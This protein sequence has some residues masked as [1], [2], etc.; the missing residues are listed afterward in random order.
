MAFFIR[1]YEEAPLT[2]EREQQQFSKGV[3]TGI[4]EGLQ[5][6][7]GTTGYRI[8]L[9]GGTYSINGIV[10][11]DDA[12]QTDFQDFGGPVSD[13]HHLVYVTYDPD[14]DT[15][16]TYSVKSGTFSSPAT[17][18]PT[19]AANGF[20]IADVWLPNTAADITDAVIN[21][22]DPLQMG[23]QLLKTLGTKKSVVMSQAKVLKS[24][25]S[26]TF[27]FDD[28]NLLALSPGKSVDEDPTRF[29]LVTHAIETGTGS[30]EYGTGFE[31]TVD[32]NGAPEDDYIMLYTTDPQDFTSPGTLTAHAM[33]WSA[34]DTAGSLGDQLTDLANLLGNDDGAFASENYYPYRPDLAN[35]VVL[36]VVDVDN[37]YVQW[38]NGVVMPVGDE[39]VDGDY[40]HYVRSISS[41]VY[42]T[43]EVPASG[44]IDL[45]DILD[46]ASILHAAGLDEAYDGF[47][48][49]SADG[50]GRIINVD[51]GP[52]HIKHVGLDGAGDAVPDGGDNSFVAALK[53]ALDATALNDPLY[54]SV[55]RGVDIVVQDTNSKRIALS[56]R[57]PYR[58][59]VN[60]AT[61]F[62]VD[63]DLTYTGGEI[64]VNF[65]SPAIS[66]SDWMSQHEN[67]E[68][69]EGKWV[70]IFDATGNASEKIYRLRVN[71]SGGYFY[72]EN[73]EGQTDIPANY[74]N[75][76]TSLPESVTQLWVWEV[77]IQTGHQSFFNDVEIHGDLEGPGSKAVSM[78]SVHEGYDN[79][80]DLNTNLA[81][82][83]TG[84]IDV[85][86]TAPGL[87]L[88]SFTDT[89]SEGVGTMDSNGEFLFHMENAS[90]GNPVVVNVR[91]LNDLTY[92][93]GSGVIT[94]N[95]DAEA[96]NNF[97]SASPVGLAICYKEDGGDPTL[98]VWDPS[99]YS[100]INSNNGFAA[101]ELPQ[102]GIIA[103]SS[104]IYVGTTQGLKIFDEEGAALEEDETTLGISSPNLFVQ[105]MSHDRNKIAWVV[106][107]GTN[108][109]CHILERYVDSGGSAVW[110]LHLD[111]DQLTEYD[112][113][114]YGGVKDI[115]LWRDKLLVVGDTGIC[116]TY[117]YRGP[118]TLTQENAKTFTD[119]DLIVVNMRDEGFMFIQYED[120][121]AYTYIKTYDWE[122][123]RNQYTKDWSAIDEGGVATLPQAVA[124]DG[125]YAY[126][127]D[128]GN[129]EIIKI[130]TTAKTGWWRKP[131]DF[132]K[133]EFRKL[134]EPT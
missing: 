44:D 78:T 132:T 8:S 19:E 1:S 81:N 68:H 70:E 87:R 123:F 90:L 121:T 51:S 41:T 2:F 55:E 63:A 67:L 79:T 4:F 110:E 56:M 25:T 40:T 80:Q 129:N 94:T 102:G 114:G 98:E 120:T 69:A 130:S 103:T 35:K 115:V 9:I 29:P 12:D 96:S 20:V 46:N 122:N 101:G 16:P 37:G 71:E 111:G 23:D 76:F 124:T 133:E 91:N 53:L 57:R 45:D 50:A 84:L 117:N 93:D 64:Q 106:S 107:N 49:G 17:L 95:N 86:H 27:H 72:L 105:A 52:V 60:A 134:V 83:Q 116:N 58:D 99:D 97:I 32:V 31:V 3:P 131:A 36:A 88:D 82:G 66:V 109:W 38:R 11:Y 10:I 118:G 108:H 26:Y 48:T 7:H 6:H 128:S 15:E 77:Y 127:R 125:L 104:Q 92:H 28:L 61:L 85:Y 33:G 22:R 34:T 113:T 65:T 42:G 119:D 126:F 43:S 75:D 39:F 54:R 21:N 5:V 112:G 73:T 74:P 18:T 14:N 47:E 13:E 62:G 100:L 89:S 59:T 24:G 30:G